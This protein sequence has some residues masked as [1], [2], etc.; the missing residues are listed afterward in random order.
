MAFNSLSDTTEEIYSTTK[1][2][3]LDKGLTEERL[4]VY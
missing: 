4:L 1:K 2:K 3:L